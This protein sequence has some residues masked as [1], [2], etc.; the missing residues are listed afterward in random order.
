MVS[1]DQ[2]YAYETFDLSIIP[3]IVPPL[4]PSV[5]LQGCFA[6][7][8]PFALSDFMGVEAEALRQAQ[9]DA[10]RHPS[11]AL[12]TSAQDEAVTTE[13]DFI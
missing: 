9:D 10:L 6:R 13:L 1:H 7:G 8:L 4:A 12:R 2:R 5:S 3:P 11:T